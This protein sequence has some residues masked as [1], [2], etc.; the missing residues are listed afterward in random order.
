MAISF[1]FDLLSN[2]NFLSLILGC[3]ACVVFQAKALQ[4]LFRKEMY[5][6]QIDEYE[7]RNY[8]L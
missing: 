4:Y 7:A 6:M 3:I 5:K 2:Y 8:F 1:Y